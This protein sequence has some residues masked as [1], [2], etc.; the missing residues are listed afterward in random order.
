M[1][2]G[3]NPD[4]LKKIIDDMKILCNFICKLYESYKPC[5]TYRS[6]AYAD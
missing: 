3:A 6:K 2:W 4:L 1:A 5:A